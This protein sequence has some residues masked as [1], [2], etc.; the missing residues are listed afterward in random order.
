MESL[1]VA[2]TEEQL[3]IAIRMSTPR[4]LNA[5]TYPRPT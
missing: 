4:P 5:K 3:P 1:A 2:Q